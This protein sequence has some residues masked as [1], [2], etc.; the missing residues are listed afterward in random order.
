[1]REEI[2]RPSQRLFTAI[3]KIWRVE[4]GWKK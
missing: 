1:M 4:W 2:G 3:E